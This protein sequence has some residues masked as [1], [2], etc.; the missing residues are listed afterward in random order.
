M[1]VVASPIRSRGCAQ[2][3]AVRREGRVV[4]IAM[5]PPSRFSLRRLARLLEHEVA[6]KMGSE[7]RDMD[8]RT[9]Y[10]LGNVPDWAKGARIRYQ[11]RAPNQMA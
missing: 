1:V 8:E 10:S 3:G 5:A 9:M 7:H 4:V 11:G 2:I 6:H